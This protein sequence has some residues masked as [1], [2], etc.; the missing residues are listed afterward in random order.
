M[1]RREPARPAPLESGPGVRYE[2]ATAI[3]DGLMSGIENT[4]GPEQVALQYVLAAKATQD[5][6]EA[7]ECAWAFATVWRHDLHNPDFIEPPSGLL[8]LVEHL[9]EQPVGPTWG[10]PAGDD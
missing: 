5:R 8:V 7:I 2:E 10:A 9:I 6:A 4:D 3:I 1:S